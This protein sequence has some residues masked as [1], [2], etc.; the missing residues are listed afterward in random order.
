MLSAEKDGFDTVSSTIDV[1]EGVSQVV[2]LVARAL[3]GRLT[4]TTNANNAVVAIDGGEARAAPV[5]D[6]EVESG[7]RLVT[8]SAP[9]YN[10]D[11]QYVDIAAD[12]TTTHHATLEE[13]SLDAEITQLRRLFD[14]RSYEAAAEIADLLARTL[15]AWGNL[16]IDVRENLALTLAIQGRALYA[17][18][19][20]TG[21]VQP[22]Y[23]AVRFGQQIELPIKHRHGGGGFRQGFCTGVLVYGPDEIA[24]RSTDDP[25]HGFAVEPQDIT[26][27]RRAE[28]Q[29]GYLSRLNTEVE[30]R[31][32]MDFVHPDS[33]QQR[34][35]PDS[36]LVTDIVCRNCNHAL[37]VH[38]QLLLFL[39]RNTR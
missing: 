30:G 33:E 4:V 14:N 13:T 1:A 19:N 23:N 9:G 34:R 6:I 20:F 37:A 5:E 11:E 26:E 31:G 21:S 36:P 15:V 25:D 10:T 17:L 16:G 28:A 22:L 38:E 24:F 18:G 12:A 39:T 29:E 27:I 2:E 35:D 8:V 3:P 32:S 7:A